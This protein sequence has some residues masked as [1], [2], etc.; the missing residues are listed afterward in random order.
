M[1]DKYFI[2][3]ATAEECQI[4]LKDIDIEIGLTASRIEKLK[5][6]QDRNPGWRAYDKYADDIVGIDI[7]IEEEYAVREMLDD[8]SGLLNRRIDTLLGLKAF[9]VKGQDGP[10][11]QLGLFDSQA[12]KE[13][14]GML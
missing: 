11:Y 7:R 6:T 8:T 12:K 10:V 4:Y 3:K 2:S 14:M 1:L 5:A 13:R 9:G